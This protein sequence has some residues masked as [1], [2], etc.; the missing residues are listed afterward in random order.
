MRQ[1][2]GRLNDELSPQLPFRLV[3]IIRDHHCLT[4]IRRHF[5]ALA[6]SAT[7]GGTPVSSATGDWREEF[8]CR[9]RKRALRSTIHPATDDDIRSR[10]SFSFSELSFERRSRSQSRLA[11]KTRRIDVSLSRSSL[12]LRQIHQHFQ[13]EGRPWHLVGTSFH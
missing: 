5:R 4:E 9:G 7:S 10:V 8:P 13:L 6:E 1:T 11:E 3:A 2:S 12:V